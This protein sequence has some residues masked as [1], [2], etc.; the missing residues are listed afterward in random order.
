MKKGHSEHMHTY[1]QSHEYCL[2]TSGQPWEMLRTK[3]S[4]LSSNLASG[5][6]LNLE[7]GQSKD[8]ERDFTKATSQNI[9]FANT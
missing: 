1:L 7:M 5:I 4:H 6:S 8:I 9:I 2:S 3:S